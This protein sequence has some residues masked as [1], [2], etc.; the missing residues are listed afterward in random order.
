M[1]LTAERLRR[2]VL[3]V[4]FPAGW[5]DQLSFAEVVAFSFDNG[6]FTMRDG[7]EYEIHVLPK[8]ELERLRDKDAECESCRPR[9]TRHHRLRG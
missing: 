4:G 2:G 6:T 1:T 3:V 8:G 9:P 7:S 5:S